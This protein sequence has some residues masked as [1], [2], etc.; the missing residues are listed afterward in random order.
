MQK[1]KLLSFD[2]EFDYL[3]GLMLQNSAIANIAELDT[4]DY[5]ILLQHKPVITLGQ[6]AKKENILASKESL[7]KKGI[8]V[9]EIDRGVD[10]TYHGP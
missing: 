1:Y 5:L 3:A 6:F 8:K 2:G 4:N 10:V 9:F 7:E